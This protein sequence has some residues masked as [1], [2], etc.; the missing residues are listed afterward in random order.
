MR[1]TMMVVMALVLF[2]EASAAPRPARAPHR[3]GYHVVHGWPKLPEGRALGSVAGVSVDRSGNVWVFHRASRAWSEPFPADAIAESTVA[4]FDGRTGQLLR[5]WGAGRFVMPHGLTVDAGGNVWL[6][7]VALQQVFKFSPDGKPLLVMGEARVAGNDGGHFNRPTQVSVAADGTV[8]VADGY[9]N[10]RVARFTADGRFLGQWGTPGKGPGQFDHPHALVIDRAGRVY[11]ADREN[12]RVQVFDAKGRFLE[13]W[14]SPA[15]GRPYGVALVGQREV[16]IAD[17]G[18]QP[19]HGPGRS[20]L[21]I[22]DRHGR[23]IE[24]VGRYGNQDG[25]FLMAHHVAAD[26]QG[27]IYVVDITGRRVQKFVR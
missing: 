25:Q 24:R 14:S 4:E 15:I 12:D 27:A 21:V 11:V 5:E 26:P 13:Q 8:L 3:A 7:D 1:Q 16:A 22:T 20:G 23:V 17:G 18:V 9:I 19:E 10:T 2:A 6:T